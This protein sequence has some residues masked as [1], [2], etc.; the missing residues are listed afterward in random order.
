MEDQS[1]FSNN[2]YKVLSHPRNDGPSVGRLSSEQA[3]VG[4]LD[5]SCVTSPLSVCRELVSV[6]DAYDGQKPLISC[7]G[8]AMDGYSALANF[9]DIAKRARAVISESNGRSTH[10]EANPR[11]PASIGS[12]AG[13][14]LPHFAAPRT[15]KSTDE[16]YTPDSLVRF[17]GHFDL[18]P[19][20]SRQRGRQLAPEYYTV[21]ED[22]L[23]R[24][25]FGRVWLNPPSSRIHPWVE[26]MKAHNDGIMLCFSR[27]DA[28]WFADLA[29]YCGGVYLPMRRMQFWRPG[30]ARRKQVGVVLFPFGEQN[31]LVLER[32]GIPGV[33]LRV[34]PN[35]V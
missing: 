6:L 11:S 28:T 5:S 4:Q 10:T 20:T 9:V 16:W 18:D 35:A 1:A 29:K 14:E 12:A 27:T 22:G 15:A 26:R 30:E 24:E 17:L 19:A 8:Q 3:P 7:Q 23:Q 13:L 21:H 32:C 34:P 33:L 31:F 25:W 2:G